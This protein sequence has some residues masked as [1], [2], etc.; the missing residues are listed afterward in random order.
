M[1]LQR[2]EHALARHDDLLRLLFHRERS[3]ERRNLL[4]GFPLGELPQTLL[5]RPHR[6]VDHLQKQ[7]PGAR[8]EDEDGA[9]DRLRRQVAL[10]RLVDRHAVHVGVVHEPNRLVRKQLAVVLRVEVRFRRLAAVQLQT[11]AHALAQYVQRGI[12]LHDLRHRLLHERLRAREPVAVRRVQVVRQVDP[13]HRARGRRV[14]GHVVGGVVQKLSARVPLDVVA[15]K[16]A[17]AQL[18]VQPEL[19]RGLLVERVLGVARQRGL[20]HGPLV[21][22]EQK[23]VRARRVHLVRLARVDGFLLHRLNLQR[24]QLLVK[25]LAQVHDDGLVDLL[26]EV[27]AEDLD[28]RDLQRGDLTVHEDAGQIELNLEPH[29]HVRAVDR[30]RPPQREPTVGDLVQA[31]PLRVG[32]LLVLHA[33]LEP[34]GL[35]PEQTLPGGEVRALEQSV[36]ENALHAP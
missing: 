4:G 29:V 19:V 10:E 23:D 9:V 18:H 27:R 21:R 13:H 25:H 2:V 17:P 14:D 33:L 7:L 31:A 34:A 28:E 35:L 20:G 1:H 6:G 5:P 32:Q 24:V 8:V 16:V 30:R 12:R 15:V 3:Y 26:P 11:L 22:R 36:L